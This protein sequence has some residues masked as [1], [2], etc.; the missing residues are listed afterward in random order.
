VSTSRPHENT[1]ITLDT[2]QPSRA[3]EHTSNDVYT[4]Q[5]AF[6][7]HTS[8]SMWTLMSTSR[9]LK[10][11]FIHVEYLSTSRT[12]ETH[13]SSGRV[14][15]SRADEHT[16]LERGTCLAGV[17]A[18]DRVVG[19]LQRPGGCRRGLCRNTT[20]IKNTLSGMHKERKDKCSNYRN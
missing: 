20:I 13:S 17:G 7:L 9:R 14:L 19:H 10:R 16:S 2:G 11:T 8:P 5:P 4:H 3:D 1:C 12:H 18:A 15:T 6:S